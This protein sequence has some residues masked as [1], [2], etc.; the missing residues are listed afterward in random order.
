MR[1]NILALAI[2]AL[3]IVL[4]FAGSAQCLQGD[5]NNG[6]GLFRKGQTYDLG[7]WKGGKL[8]GEGMRVIFHKAE[9]YYGRTNTEADFLL[10]TAFETPSVESVLKLKP[11]VV[12]K[13]VF[14][15]GELNGAGELWATDVKTLPELKWLLRFTE[16]W[17]GGT[18]SWEQMQYKGEFQVT[19]PTGYGS[20]VLAMKTATITCT[21]K[22]L[23]NP[24]N[25]D[26]ILEAE[27]PDFKNKR[28]F[29][30]AFVNGFPHGFCITNFDWYAPA[31]EGLRRQLWVYG[32]KGFTGKVGLYPADEMNAQQLKL[33]DSSVYTGPLDPKNKPVGFGRV[34]KTAPDGK[35]EWIYSGYFADG[36]RS[37]PGLFERFG[38]YGLALAGD[39][40][41]D[42]FMRGTVY[43]YGNGYFTETST[44]RFHPSTY[45]PVG[46]TGY[47]GTWDFRSA[48]E[49]GAKASKLYWG[50]FNEA[51]SYEGN[52]TITTADGATRTGIWKNGMLVQQL[53]GEIDY[54]SLFENCV[55]VLNGMASPVKRDFKTGKWKTLSGQVLPEGGKLRLSKHAYGNF[56]GRCSSCNGSGK[57]AEAHR[58]EASTTTFTS[59]FSTVQGGGAYMDSYWL[60]TTTTT[61]SYTIPA[62]TTYTYRGCSACGGGGS[63]VTKAMIAEE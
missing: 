48:F 29:R 26:V 4:P 15:Q 10:L 49:N 52:G 5:C 35:M 54:Y 2:A 57:V 59:K 8:Q 6:Y 20:M 58:V 24:N 43:T 41:R 50:G 11:Q 46:G 56:H 19:K 40:G 3:G 36:E 44:T 18:W 33:A 13:G 45:R 16:R 38:Q 53:S 12:I 22:E 28:V 61:S 37:G 51:G 21:G 9:G 30:G 1:K 31:V 55:V 47:Q 23:T 32:Q 25:P 62:Y 42:S 60:K 34:V 14:S 17:V 27:S 63:G 7:N 39:F